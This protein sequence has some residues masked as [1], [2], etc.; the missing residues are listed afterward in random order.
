[1]R[2]RPEVQSCLFLFD[3]RPAII[4]AGN[5][6]T[7]ADKASR[8]VSHVTG[9]KFAVDKIVVVLVSFAKAA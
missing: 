1:L 9:S 3:S 4:G 2:V 6:G 8:I 5:W 7:N